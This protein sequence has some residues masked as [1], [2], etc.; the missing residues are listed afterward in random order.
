MCILYCKPPLLFI[1]FYEH[2][3]VMDKT[4]LLEQL[5]RFVEIG[6]TCY[7]TIWFKDY[8]DNKKKEKLKPSLS[9]KD[10][11]DEIQPLLENIKE[12]FDADSVC[13]WEG[14][15][16]ETTLSG[17]HKKKLSIVLEV[18]SNTEHCAMQDMENIPVNMF[19]RQLNELRDSSTD[20]IVSY[21]DEKDDELSELYKSYNIRTI[22]VFKIN[23]GKS[24][25]KW[26]GL[27]TV[28]F[29]E[30]RETL[31]HADLAWI[32]IQAARIGL[33]LTR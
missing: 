27:L 12:E 23:T 11:Y 6:S 16:G 2:S 14:S 33:K 26:T 31:T 24:V 1:N 13:L 20:Y 9:D 3:C 29:K 22:A 5:I 10:Y 15:N 18:V 19:K 21:E 25:K 4:T 8:L 7:G 30:K 17:F 28:A 32:N